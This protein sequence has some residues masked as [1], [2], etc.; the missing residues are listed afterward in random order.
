MVD[1]DADLA[2]IFEGDDLDQVD[3]VFTTNGGT[4]NGRG[5][6]N[7]PSEVIDVQS[8]MLAANA[9][10][11]TCKTSSHTGVARND[12]VV[13]NTVTYSVERILPLGGGMSDI[14]LQT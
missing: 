3:A 7:D 13:I 12:T 9:P 6:F 8:G 1:L 10:T 5:F 14:Y 4:V 2:A 11:F